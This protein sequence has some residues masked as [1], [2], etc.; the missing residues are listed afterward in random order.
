MTHKPQYGINICSLTMEFDDSIKA[1]KIGRHQ[2]S[3]MTHF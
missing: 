2:K 3:E 1:S